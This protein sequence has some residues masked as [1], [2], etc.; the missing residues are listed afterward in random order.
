MTYAEAHGS[1]EYLRAD[2]SVESVEIGTRRFFE[3]AD[4]K[5][6]SWNKPLHKEGAPFA[7]IFDYEG[8]RGKRVLEI[9]CGM[10][11]MAMN[12]AMQ[13]AKVTAID[14]NP[15]AIKETK[16]RFATFGLEGDIQEVDAETLPFES[17]SFD[18]VYSWGVLHHTPGIQ[19]AINEILRVLVPGGRVGLMLYNR[20]SVLYG[21]TVA[22]EE[23]IVNLEHSFLDEAALAS[24]YGDGGREEGNPHT[25]PATEREVRRDLL[26]D[27][28]DVEVRVLG[29]DLPDI[30]NTWLPSLSRLMTASM[31][32]AL[33]RRFGW[34]LWITGRKPNA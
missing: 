22:Y 1:T 7:N 20:Q 2:G 6:L 28:E 24:R 23:G 30:L 19:L 29:T 21:Y 26:I 16:H 10:G 34:S 25:W 33:A 18:F 3:L 14:L 8:L 15:T 17:E 31:M 5:F 12:W 11:F 13:G 27:Y 32:D 4:Q 9:G